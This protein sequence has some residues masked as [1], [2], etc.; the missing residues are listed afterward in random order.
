MKLL[1]AYLCYFSFTKSSLED[2]KEL[3]KAL[4]SCKKIQSRVTALVKLLPLST[5]NHVNQNNLI[6][7]LTSINV[8]R[9]IFFSSWSLI[10]LLKR[11]HTLHC[12]KCPYS[13]LS[14]FV[15]SGIRISPYS[16][17]MRENKEQNNSEYGHFLRSASYSGVL[18]D[19]LSPF[20]HNFKKHVTA[21]LEMWN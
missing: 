2:T 15:F 17:R 12:M 19:Y 1:V 3:V 16:V 21:L 18:I 6:A 5:R 7:G 9:A 13:E 11:N 8:P 10:D 4:F 14:W 20:S